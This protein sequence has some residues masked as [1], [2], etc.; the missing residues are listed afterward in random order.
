MRKKRVVIILVV[1]VLL[2]IILAAL[3]RLKNPDSPGALIND[4]PLKY[5]SL[6]WRIDQ[7]LSAINKSLDESLTA[8]KPPLTFG[9][10]ALVANGNRGE[11]LINNDA[12]VGATL[13]LDRFQELG[14]QG[15]TVAI[16]YPILMPGFNRQGE[17]LDFYKKY[18]AEVKKRGMKMD[19]EMGVV[20]SGTDFSPL[21][22]DYSS[23]SASKYV[24]D[25]RTMAQIIINEL[26]PDYL[27]LGSE[28][29]TFADLTGFADYNDPELYAQNVQD[30]I[31]AMYKGNTLV[32][33][34][35][36]SWLP[37]SFVE[38]LV[39]VNGLDFLSLHIYPLSTQIL[40]N[41]SQTITL[42]K[43]NNLKVVIDEAWL[44]KV[45]K[46][47]SLTDVAANADIFKRD[48]Y[49]FWAALDQQFLDVLLKIAQSGDVEYI[50]PFWS[51]YFFTYLDYSS[52]YENLTY[53]QLLSI[54][55][56]QQIAAIVNGTFSSTGE[57]YK[58]L[59]NNY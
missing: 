7:G 9:T 27:N 57:Y 22:V 41:I 8:T 51:R 16:P 34:G 1:V 13:E 30:V 46:G 37:I 42:A 3:S 6:Y 14:I 5:K 32:G 12:I 43:Q 39:Q 48:M 55:H 23:L 38:S 33:A 54:F 53:T 18:A 28:P 25:T 45:D 21:S 20:F 44:Y 2:V 11:D 4:A 52:E 17:Y 58:E 49:S 36:S 29:D 19:V 40:D 31:S 50:S 35:A 26:S 10:E 15:V 24:H 56:E 59:I 47:D